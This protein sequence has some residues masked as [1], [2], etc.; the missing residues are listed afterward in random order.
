M[1]V[2]PVWF[3]TPVCCFFAGSSRRIFGFAMEVAMSR[4]E[5]LT[6]K[7]DS[8]ETAAIACKTGEGREILSRFA[9]TIRAVR[10]SM[11]VEEAV[12]E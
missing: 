12:Q 6:R 1:A 9:M 10:D 8:L 7:A 11:T 3:G 5:R 4:Y 2:Y